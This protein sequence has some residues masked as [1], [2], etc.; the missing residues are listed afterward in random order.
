MW[1]GTDGETGAREDGQTKAR[2]RELR[3]EGQGEKRANE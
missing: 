2:V 3:A 1:T